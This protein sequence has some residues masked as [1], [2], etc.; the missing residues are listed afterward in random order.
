MKQYLKANAPLI[1]ILALCAAVSLGVVFARMGVES[2]NKTYDVVLDYN[3]LELLAEQSEH[4]V[5]W[6][7]GEFK[8][9]GIT[10]V[11]L[12]EESL[13]SLVEN[14]GMDVTAE[15]MDAVTQNADWRGNYPDAFIQELDTNGFDRFD[16]LV[17][18]SGADAVEFVRF[19]VES[20]LHDEDYYYYL[21]KSGE[22]TK[23]YLV[24]DGTVT[25]TLYL[26]TFPYIDDKGD[27]FTQRKEIASSTLMYISLGLMPEKVTLIQSLGMEIIPRT[28]CYNGHNDTKYA[29]AVLDGYKQYGIDPEYLI[30]GGEAVIGFDDGNT[31]A[32]DY[33]NSNDITIGLIETTTQRENIMQS[34]IEAITR[35]T[36]YNTVRV[37]SVWDYIQYRYGYYGYEGAEEIEN[38]LFRAIVERNI[39]I[40]YFKPIKYTDSAYAYVTDLAVYQGMF[41]SLEARLVEHGITMG[42]ASVMDDMQIPSLALLA[43]GLGAGLGGALLPST[44]LPMKKKWTTL[45]AGA[46][47]VC[48]AA[49]WFVM[50]NTFRL[51]ASFASAVVFAC[52]AAAFMLYAA[53]STAGKLSV[54]AKLTKIL[55]RA[56]AILLI[57]VALALIGAMMTAAPLSSTDYMLE[58]GIF[59]GVKLA[60]LAPLAFFC[61]IFVSYY[62]IFEKERKC[63]TLKIRDI[64]TALQWTIPVWALVLVGVIGIVGYYYIARTGHESSVSVSTFELILRN[65]LEENLLARPRT[66]EFLVAFPCIMLAVYSA[67][68]R[69]PFFTAVF[70]LAGTIGLTSICNT[71]MHIRT[72]L[73]LGFVRTGYAVLLGI[74]IGTILVIGFD[75]LCRAWYFI[76]KKYMEAELNE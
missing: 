44:F 62:G 75:L 66:K 55:P 52:L 64:I 60:Q 58:L 70:G 34:G 3:E 49:A 18:V 61:V 35:E 14:S 46:A 51:V 1:V 74:L 54:D 4:D 9:M 6:W 29:K 76:R 32:M 67:V 12:Q 7:L 23:L 15:M 2:E 30:A 33:I 47:A 26:T 39:R 45:L 63:S 19:A 13:T 42:R 21:D 25:D 22:D 73:Y 59:R 24:L 20:R 28:I 68:R 43:L 50:P 31:I 11:G 27:G 65:V 37:F 40:I 71:F 41:E 8:K 48:V 53:K 36:G 69:M 38:T 72:P 56:C 17:E 57:S 16:V 10:R 5:S